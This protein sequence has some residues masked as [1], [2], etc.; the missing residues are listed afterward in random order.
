[1][2]CTARTVNKRYAPLQR[3]LGKA[4]ALLSGIERHSSYA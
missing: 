3:L 1:M 2:T 4:P